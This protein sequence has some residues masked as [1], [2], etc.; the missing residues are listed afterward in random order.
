MTFKN[1]RQLVLIILIL[2]LAGIF[3]FYNLTS[4]D[5][6]TDEALIGFRS[7][8]YID[9][10]ASPYQTTPYEWLAEIPSWAKL[11]FHD[12]PPLVFLIQHIIFNLLGVSIFTLRLPFVLAGILSVYFVYLITK[13]LFGQTTGLISAILLAVSPMHIW[14]SRIGLQES[15]VILFSLITFYYFIKAGDDD[16]HWKW[17]IALGFALLTKYTAIFLLPIFVIYFLVYNRNILVNKYF[18]QAILLIAIIF[19][20]VIFYNLNLY[21]ERGHFDLQLSYLFGQNVSE[22][23]FLPGKIQAGSLMDRLINL[24]PN[25]YSSLLAPM[26]IVFVFSVAYGL[27]VLIRKKSAQNNFLFLLLTTILFYTLSLLA[28]GSAF[29]FITVLIPFATILIAW[30]ISSQRKL[31]KYL[32]LASILIFEI[33]FSFNTLFINT[34]VGRQNVAYSAVKW[35]SYDWGYNQLNSYIQGLLYNKR[36]AVSFAT[37]Y[38]FLE[39]IKAESREKNKDKE[40]FPVLLIYDQNMYDLATLWI[41][42]RQLVYQGW[43]VVTADDYLSQDKEFWTNQGIKSFYF[44]SI[45]DKNILQKSQI[46]KTNGADDLLEILVDTES[47]IIKRPDGREVFKVYYWQ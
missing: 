41:F 22:W 1:P 44:F 28:T 43:P 25:L 18:W 2:I 7:I 16:K 39:D 11:S 34:P 42:H 32:I 36:P 38:E 13:K 4:A 10:F 31:V 45:E 27:Y 9:F 17:G 47:E 35:D 46:E 24:V 29:R 8:G 21:Q 33:F 23:E 6:I 12:H 3:R 37:N 40:L 26:F 5:V 19:S 14:I 15:I 20:P 30:T